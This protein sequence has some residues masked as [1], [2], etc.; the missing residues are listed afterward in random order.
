MTHFHSV[1]SQ[2]K[3]R[4]HTSLSKTCIAMIHQTGCVGPWSWFDLYPTI[5]TN[6]PPSTLW[7]PVGAPSLPDATVIAKQC[8]KHPTLCFELR[9]SNIWRS[10]RDWLDLCS[11]QTSDLCQSGWWFSFARWAALNKCLARALC[12]AQS[13]LGKFFHKIVPSSS[14]VRRPCEQIWE[15]ETLSE[16]GKWTGCFSVSQRVFHSLTS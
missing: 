3:T 8:R 13:G 16:G 11:K 15:A 12:A 10:R 14:N 4:C 5:P 6:K 7:V 2:V 9:N 1:S